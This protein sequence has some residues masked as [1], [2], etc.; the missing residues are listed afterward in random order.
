MIDVFLHIPKCGGSTIRS[1][2]MNKFSTNKV[3]RIYGDQGFGFNFSR[4]NFI[5]NFSRVKDENDIKA[6]SGHVDSNTFRDNIDEELENFRFFSFLRDPIERGISNINYMR[7][8]I[9][10]R[11]HLKALI[12]NREIY[13]CI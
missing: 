10:H 4:E 11:S 6:I 7:F 2:I 12:I 9:N 3:V 13:L 5:K 8:N 1:M